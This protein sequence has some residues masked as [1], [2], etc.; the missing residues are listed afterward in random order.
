MTEAG[1]AKISNRPIWREIDAL[2]RE[3]GGEVVLRHNRSHVGSRDEEKVDVR[4]KKAA[5]RSGRTRSAED[6]SPE[7][8]TYFFVDKAGGPITMGIK[9]AVKRSAAEGYAR[10][11]RAQL[12]QGHRITYLREEGVSESRIKGGR[13]W[14]RILT[15]TLPTGRQNAWRYPNLYG[16]SRCLLCGEEEETNRHWRFRCQGGR[17]M[18]GPRRRA[19]AAVEAAIV[20]ELGPRGMAGVWSVTRAETGGRVKPWGGR[21]PVLEHVRERKWVSKGPG[22]AFLIADPDNERG[23][24]VRVRDDVYWKLRA[25]WKGEWSV[26]GVEYVRELRGALLKLVPGVRDGR[27]T[28]QTKMVW[29]SHPSYGDIIRDV[30]GINGTACSDLRNLDPGF[31]WGCTLEAPGGFV[32]GLRADGSEICDTRV[33][34]DGLRP[35]VFEN[36]RVE[37]NPEFDIADA[38]RENR[39]GM[40]GR[41]VELAETSDCSLLLFPLFRGAGYEGL[42]ERAGGVIV[43]R[44]PPDTWSFIPDSYWGGAHATAGTDT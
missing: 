1:W 2:R 33:L 32:G 37:A 21:K 29:A 38:R 23:E 31:D 3:T 16:T 19:A 43:F 9:R 8:T 12:G 4:A 7:D 26:S 13:L 25:W 34:R 30:G 5:R 40:V 10:E 42:I 17:G 39:L 6:Y 36:N 41:V 14:G 27:H 11:I 44:A 22:R 20:R 18:E 35:E 28:R 24:K 15:S